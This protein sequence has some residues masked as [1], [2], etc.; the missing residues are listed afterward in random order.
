MSA[1]FHLNKHLNKPETLARFVEV[2]RAGLGNSVAVFGNFKEFRFSRSVLLF[3]R[4]FFC[5]AGIS[6]R[7]ADNR[8][9]GDEHRF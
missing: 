1:R 4:H 5:K 9:E 3:F 8:A 2:S 7:V 6:F